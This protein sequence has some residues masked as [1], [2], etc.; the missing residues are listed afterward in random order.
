MDNQVQPQPVQI[1][2]GTEANLQNPQVAGVNYTQVPLVTP[3]SAGG[4]MLIPAQPMVQYTYSQ[5]PLT[6]L[7]VGTGAVIRQE[8]DFLGATT[9]CDKPAKYHVYVQTPMGLRYFFKCNEISTCCDRCCCSQDTRGF[10]MDI[11]HIVAENEMTSD[12]AQNYFSIVKPCSCM[13]CCRPTM[14]VRSIIGNKYFG[15]IREPCCNCAPGV[16]VY[17]QNS[18]LWYFITTECC[19]SGLCCGAAC[20]KLNDIHFYVMQDGV[21]KGDVCKMSAQSFSEFKTK[22]DSFMVQFPPDST[23]EQKMMLIVATLLLDLEYFG[24]SSDE[25]KK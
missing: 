19:Q 10:Q 3:A 13:V 22:A 8:A 21:R 17:D 9:G 12:L 18:N 20:T 24:S 2:P 4:A 15:K 7:S 14:E 5:D 11:K 23:P 1:S 6:Q 16:E 25:S